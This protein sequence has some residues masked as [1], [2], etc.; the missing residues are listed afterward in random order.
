MA[1]FFFLEFSAGHPKRELKEHNVGP[2]KN[3]F[4]S[5]DSK[6]FLRTAFRITLVPLLT[7]SLISYSLWIYLEMNYSFFLANGFFPDP[8]MKQVFV[9]S[10]MASQIDF[11][12]WVAGFIVSVFFVGLFVAH[13]VLRPFGRVVQLCQEVLSGEA[14]DT[15]LDPFHRRKLV[16]RAALLFNQYVH[17]EEEECAVP[18]DLEKIRGPVSD[19]VFYFQYGL[20]IAILSAFTG[21]AIY[22][23]IEHLHD[24]IVTTAMELLQANKSIGTFLTSQ[25]ESMNVIG[26][27]CTAFSVGL[28]ALL[29]KGIIRE[30]EG[31]SYGYLRDIRD[32]TSGDHAK[33]LHPRFNDPGK[34]AAFAINQV[35]D[36]LFPKAEQQ[37]RERQNVLELKP[38]VERE[39]PPAFIEEFHSQDGQRLYRVVIPSG[40]VVEGLS[41][42]DAL[43][44]LKK[45]G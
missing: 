14:P 23:T 5:Q 6:Y 36:H 8:E 15:D 38:H 41:Y 9:D 11:L 43:D 4:Q 7:L 19:Y 29:S 35:M 42:E 3:L 32:I 34:E 26:W 24:Q 21:I 45:V 25:R 27:V 10:L 22:L 12:P 2:F 20:C 37:P 13:L 16:L 1:L 30:V 33:R 39:V 18:E 28:Y 40:E 31:V 44:L 17:S